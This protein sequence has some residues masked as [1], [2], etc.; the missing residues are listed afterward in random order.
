MSEK[1]SAFIR[2]IK[3]TYWFRYIKKECDDKVI[4]ELESEIARNE[5]RLKSL[6]GKARREC[7]D[8]LRSKRN[9]LAKKLVKRDG[10]ST[11]S[12]FREFIAS[13]AEQAYFKA[14]ESNRPKNEVAKEENEA[15]RKSL[16]AF[17]RLLNKDWAKFG[18]GQEPYVK[19]KE[20]D[21][22]RDLTAIYPMNGPAYHLGP[23][24][25]FRVFEAK[26]LRQAVDAF[27][28]SVL[29]TLSENTVIQYD[30]RTRRVRENLISREHIEK[31]Y[32][33]I[34][35]YDGQIPVKNLQSK[36]DQATKVFSLSIK[37][38]PDKNPCLHSYQ[39]ACLRLA[40][41][42]IN[43]KYFGNETPLK[44][45]IHDGS[46]FSE[47]EAHYKIPK[48]SWFLN[49]SKGDDVLDVFLCAKESELPSHF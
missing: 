34:G 35:V 18:T 22:L 17:S 7:R 32:S 3:V 30:P 27:V 38:E 11:I 45:A 13:K 33:Y 48:E 24:L 14:F 43:F 26:S 2:N 1:K 25:I 39:T 23:Q 12:E 21:V 4:Q 15:Q 31:I 42:F 37:G 49:H 47:I 40:F 20:Y 41:D 8:G 6:E 9:S 28:D 16:E 44:Y 46:I 36:L 19:Y 10:V 5:S 29:F